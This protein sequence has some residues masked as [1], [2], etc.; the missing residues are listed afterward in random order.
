MQKA[1]VEHMSLLIADF[2][3]IDCTNTYASEQYVLLDVTE[4]TPRNLGI[5]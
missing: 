4:L 3:F 2:A 1:Q 5:I